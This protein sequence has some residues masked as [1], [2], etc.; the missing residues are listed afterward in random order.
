MGLSSPN[1]SVA[2]V[3]TD[4]KYNILSFG[5]TDKQG[6]FHAERNAY[7]RLSSVSIENNHY[8]FVTL[9][10]CT[11]YGKTPPCLDLILKNKPLTLFYGM[12]D[13]NP[14]VSQQD[15]LAQCEASGI[16]VVH[17]PQIAEISKVYLA[18]F[19]ERILHKRPVRFIKTAISKE[20]YYCRKD[21]QTVSISTE[22]SH[23]FTM[24]LR[25]K[26]D[27]VVVGQGTTF[28]D[29]PSLDCRKP[30]VSKLHWDTLKDQILKENT[31]S[32]SDQFFH[33]L[34]VAALGENRV[35]WER[36]S[37]YQPFRVFLIDGRNSRIDALVQKQT[38][39][40]QHYGNKKCIFFLVANSGQITL[41]NLDATSYKKLAEISFLDPISI[42]SLE[43]IE[44][45]ISNTLHSVGC[46]TIL[47][48]GG[49]FLYQTFSRN[50]RPE[51]K[52]IVIQSQTILETG[53]EPDIDFQSLELSFTKN[54]STDIWKVYRT[55][56]YQ[57]SVEE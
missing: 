41:P 48:E 23:W 51:D 2:C 6:G 8:T 37:E 21:K 18:P 12:R 46:N 7:N 30:V 33:Q 17:D 5:S 43:D 42:A 36:L 27:A 32:H 31:F 3:I 47:I 10:P 54:V 19:F 29:N 9:E 38:K 11:H 26:V 22:S 45:Q 16:S 40:N 44:Q 52:V 20:G 57:K 13:P 4:T 49:N 14:L 28:F 25:A 35:E 24:L 34:F 39:I 56:S 55:S 15:G 1:P 53:N 50:L